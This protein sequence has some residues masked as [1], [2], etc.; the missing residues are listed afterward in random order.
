MNI[1]V[2]GQTLETEEINRG[3]GVYFKN[4]LGDMIK[5]TIGNIWYIT[6]SNPASLK[7]LDAWVANR[8]TPI[9]DEYFAPSFDYN[10]ED[11]YTDK[12]NEC[13]EKYHIDCYWNPNPVMVNVLFPNKKINCAFFAMMHDII[14]YVMPIKEWS[15]TVTIEYHRRLQYIKDV[16]MLCNSEA[17]KTDY[18]NHIGNPKSV[19]VALLAAN[20]RIFYKERETLNRTNEI[21]IVFA[22]GF[23]YRKNIER[24][25]EAFAQAQ[26]RI[27]GKKAIFYIVCKYA[28]SEKER[29]QIKLQQLNIAERVVLTG[30]IPDE[31]LA[32]LYQSAD[33]FFFPSLY[34]GF[35]L[36]L[37]E[38]ML[39]GA[40]I[41]SADNS[42][43][44]EVCKEHALYCNAH[45]VDDMAAKLVEAVDNSLKES[46]EEKQNRQKYALGFTWEKTAEQTYAAMEKAIEQQPEGRKK[47]ALVTPWPKQQT[48]IA[49][50]VYRLV[51]AL[52][53]YFD[54]DIFV[55]NVL[56]MESELLPNN[57]GNR[58]LI[59][60]LEAKH[61]DYDKI[62]YQIGNS[63]E[64]HSAIYRMFK[65]YNG[66]A[67]IHDF[68]IEPFFYH[69]Y[70]LEGEQEVY[71]QALQDGYG[72]E[73]RRQFEAVKCGEAYTD[74]ERFPMC[75]SVSNIAEATIVHNEWSYHRLKSEN[76]NYFIPLACIENEPVAQSE[77]HKAYCKI[78]RKI[79]YQDGEIIIGCFGWINMNKRPQVVIES[80]KLLHD[81]FQYKVKLVFWGK[82]NTE[83]IRIM[84]EEQGLQNYIKI[85]GYLDRAEYEEALKL[86]D[87]IVN[88]RYPSMGESSATLCEAFKAQ[89]AVIVSAVNQY[90][91]FSD[92]VCWKVPVGGSEQTM[93]VSMI[94]TLIDCPEI[95]ESLAKN[96]KKY[97]D[98]KLNVENIAKLYWKILSKE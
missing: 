36:P 83:E 20:S 33:V 49:N 82:N 40:Y 13:I 16:N 48:G 22:G 58:Y 46:L 1:L 87:I 72:E 30:Y 90:K 80:I 28:Q 31:E 24:A 19:T 86:T 27:N 12:L 42:S 2:D 54:I 5:N 81:L 64:Y 35:G 76:R 59:N 62:I 15:E 21:K 88:L 52:Y 67:E 9:A 85:S 14:P 53:K 55:D 65:K 78:C 97:A 94:K 47:I 18:I 68:I 95:K 66:I 96:A 39:G 7:K 10:R 32:A 63:K 37:V 71:G 70:Y 41:L 38:A 98:E 34:E 26:K 17:T 73:G 23:D 60:E 84:I 43:L 44:P 25:V 91:E 4:V 77:Q 3:I 6:V 11:I 45:N 61:A 51:P 89:K 79:D 29:F 8:V 75:H 50:Y 57:Y 93:L 69:T 56:D 74:S 92:D